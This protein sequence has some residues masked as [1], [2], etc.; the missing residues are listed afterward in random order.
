MLKWYSPS[1]WIGFP[2]NASK[3][4]LHRAWICHCI[5]GTGEDI[6]EPT[7]RSDTLIHIGNCL[8]VRMPPTFNT[9]SQMLSRSKVNLIADTS[10]KRKAVGLR[11]QSQAV[12]RGAATFPIRG[13]GPQSK[14]LEFG[15]PHLEHPKLSFV[16]IHYGKPRWP[17]FHTAKSTVKQILHNA[18]AETE[19]NAGGRAFI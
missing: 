13:L 17:Y 9:F 2:A 7:I 8:H 18:K 3:C 1:T 4:Y 16:N 12:G 15:M 10:G 19:E 5:M 14:P 6:K 11:P